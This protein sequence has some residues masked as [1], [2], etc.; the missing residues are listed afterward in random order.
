MGYH[1]RKPPYGNNRRW[2]TPAFQA[3]Q[4]IHSF[5]PKGHAVW[6]GLHKLQPVG[7]PIPWVQKEFRD[8]VSQQIYI[9]IYTPRKINSLNLKMIVWKMVL[10]FLGC[11]LRFHVNF[12]GVYTWVLHLIYIWYHFTVSCFLYVY[13]SIYV[14][15][16]LS[17]SIF[18]F[19]WHAP[20]VIFMCLKQ[21]RWPKRIQR[22]VLLMTACW[23]SSTRLS[24]AES[25]EKQS[26]SLNVS[27]R[28]SQIFD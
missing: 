3:S 16:Y 14:S 23:P 13:L 21:I 20:R 4:Q 6:I 8:V 27:K 2:S 1:F 10:L 9:Y 26:Q 28:R 25:T 17:M 7:E 12:R 5:P 15:T 19:S 18:V 11:I 24:N 22:A